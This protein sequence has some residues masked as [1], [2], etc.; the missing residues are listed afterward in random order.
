MPTPHVLVAV[1]TH[2]VSDA[3]LAEAIRRAAGRGAGLR[4]AHVVARRGPGAELLL[5][6]PDPGAFARVARDMVDRAADSARRLGE[7]DLSVEVLT[8]QGSA[9]EVLTS[10]AA[11][12]E[13]VVLQR[14]RLSSLHRIFAGSVTTVVADRAG[15]PVVQVPEFWGPW[16]STPPVVT[17]G[18]HGPQPLRGDLLAHAFAE[19]SA[20]S[21]RLRVLH[22]CHLSTRD[23]GGYVEPAVLARRAARLR[24]VLEDAVAALGASHPGVEAWVD[25]AEQRPVDALVEA[26]R[27]SQLLV[28]GGGAPAPAGAGLGALTRSVLREALCPVELLPLAVDA[29]RPS[30]G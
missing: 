20:R 28:L 30:T 2:G 26:T 22:A 7:P 27:T 3:V 6:D 19:A 24:P 21:A 15:V 29:I 25:V 8:A 5:P 13:C 1:G 16:P 23:L 9:A 11:Q 10:L 12:A 17:V 14:R 4:L 18:V